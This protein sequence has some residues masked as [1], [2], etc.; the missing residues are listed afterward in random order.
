MPLDE[1]ERLTRAETLVQRV[2]DVDLEFSQV[3]MAMLRS[4]ALRWGGR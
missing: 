4:S 1:F 2:F 3:Q